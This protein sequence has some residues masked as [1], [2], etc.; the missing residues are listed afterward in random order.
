MANVILALVP[1]PLLPKSAREMRW[2]YFGRRPPALQGHSAMLLQHPQAIVG[3]RAC[4]SVTRHSI[5]R[6]MLRVSL[7]AVGSKSLGRLQVIHGN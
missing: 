5:L 3:T 2:P 7:S 4:L 6:M 1:L